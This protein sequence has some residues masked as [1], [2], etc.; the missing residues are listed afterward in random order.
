MKGLEKRRLMK[1]LKSLTAIKMVGFKVLISDCI[2]SFKGT[3]YA[4]DFVREINNQVKRVVSFYLFVGNK[5]VSKRELN[6]MKMNC[7]K[8][9]A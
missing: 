1:S 7:V 6:L 3:M 2:R 4:K 5:L 9:A 8:F